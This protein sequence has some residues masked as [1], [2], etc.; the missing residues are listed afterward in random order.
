MNEVERL[1][2]LDAMDV[3][4][5]VPRLNLVGAKPSVLCDLTGCE[6]LLDLPVKTDDPVAKQHSAITG[7]ETIAQLQNALVGQKSSAPQKRM[8]F[9]SAVESS[10]SVQNTSAQSTSKINVRFQWAVIQPTQELLVLIPVAQYEKNC[11][12]LLKNILVAIGIDDPSLTSVENFVWPPALS[13]SLNSTAVNNSL[14]DAQQ[15]LQGF[16]EG[17]QLKQKLNP[18]TNILVF[19]GNLGKAVF[20]GVTIVGVQIR[21]LPSLQLMSASSPEKIAEAKKV[22]WQKLKDLK[23]L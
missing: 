2:Y 12:K 20:E 4:S 1:A 8:P 17:Y 14:V 21:I 7:K 18:L 13:S 23:K 9:V 10:S 6:V 16:I 3:I 15:T 5:Y 11:I 19:D 22:T